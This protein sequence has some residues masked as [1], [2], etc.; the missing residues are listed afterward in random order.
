MRRGT[1][2][3]TGRH[4]RNLQRGRCRQ[5]CVGCSRLRRGA[6]ARFRAQTPYDSGTAALARGLEVGDQRV[7]VAT[8]L[9]EHRADFS[10]L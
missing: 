10:P 6:Q 7:D 4:L 9:V 3:K 5:G 2:H 8:A 1:S